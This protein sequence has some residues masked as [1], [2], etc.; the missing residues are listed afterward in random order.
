MEK[1]SC[2]CGSADNQL[3]VACSG[4]ADLGYIADQ[5]ARRMSLEN[6]CKMSCLALFATCA[7]E[8][9]ANFKSECLILGIQN[10]KDVVL[11]QSQKKVINGTK[12]S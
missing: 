7:D 3:V 11:L 8:Q 12:V 1:K 9:I 10:G 2:S 6:V 5:V 4:A